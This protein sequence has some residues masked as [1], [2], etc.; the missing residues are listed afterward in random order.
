MK[1]ICE[2]CGLEECKGALGYICQFID[3]DWVEL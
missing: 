2:E 1:K 3:E